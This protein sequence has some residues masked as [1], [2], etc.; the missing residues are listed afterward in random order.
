VKDELG[1]VRTV[2]VDRDRRRLCI[3]SQKTRQY[4][5][6]PIVPR[7]MELLTAL[8]RNEDRE[9][10]TGR[11][12]HNPT[13]IGQK[14]VQGA[15]VHPWR[16]L[17][18]SLRSSCENVWKTERVAEATYSAWLGHSIT[19]SRN[20]DVSPLDVEFEAVIGRIGDQ[21]GTAQGGAAQ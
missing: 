8:G 4:R 2:S 9:T 1:E 7:L 18:Q 3:V 12:A 20:H 17:F 21:T 5:E 14:I 19:V 15:T 6:V 16:K 11:G 10:V 13:R